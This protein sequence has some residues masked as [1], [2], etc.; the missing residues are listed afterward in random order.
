MTLVEAGLLLFYA[1]YGKGCASTGSL[2]NSEIITDPTFSFTISPPVRWTYY[3][4]VMP[5]AG[6]QINNFFPGQSITSADA[7]QA[8]QNEV[9][10]SYLEALSQIPIPTNDVTATV[11]YSPDPISNCYMGVIIPGEIIMIKINQNKQ[12]NNIL[13]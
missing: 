9:M 3:P 8:A 5:A 2:R 12:I 13:H 4:P 7:L 6:Q 11:T 10:A 1:A